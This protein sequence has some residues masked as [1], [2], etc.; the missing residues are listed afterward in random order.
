MSCIFFC[1]E[2]S[3]CF[4]SEMWWL[5]LILNLMGLKMARRLIAHSSGYAWMRHKSV[6][7]GFVSD[8]WP[9]PVWFI[10]YSPR[11]DYHTVSSSPAM[12]FLCWHWLTMGW[13]FWNHKL[14]PAFLLL[15]C[16][17]WVFC[18]SNRKRTNTWI[19]NSSLKFSYE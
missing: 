12:M 6:T 17:C 9:L 16:V 7:L 2:F 10:S 19:L 18:S 15:T 4:W 14:K 13:N 11:P 1:S 3:S 8:L 5:I